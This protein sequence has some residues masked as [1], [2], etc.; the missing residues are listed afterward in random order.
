MDIDLLN[1]DAKEEKVGRLNA[2]REK[3]RGKIWRSGSKRKPQRGP[4]GFSRVFL[5]V[6]VFRGFF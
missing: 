4:Q 1:P 5:R 3:R 2:G 6:M